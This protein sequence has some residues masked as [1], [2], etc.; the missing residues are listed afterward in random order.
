MDLTEAIRNKKMRGWV[1]RILQ[2][3][4]PAGFEIDTLWRQ[5]TDLGYE[6]TRTELQVN[7]A[8]LKEDGFVEN[9]QFGIGQLMDGLNNEFYKLTTK[10]IDLAEG[11]ISDPGVDL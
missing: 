2:R 10:G 6:A 8:Y 4:Y 7:L 5:L 9:P 11:T 1:V 3:A